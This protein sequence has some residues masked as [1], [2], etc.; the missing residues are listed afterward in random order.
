MLFRSCAGGVVF[1]Q[2]NVFLLQNEKHEWV[3]PKGVI[4]PGML[5]QEVAVMRVK[6]EAGIDARILCTAGETCYEFYSLTRK[7]PVCNE[8]AWYVMQAKHDGHHV[9]ASL[10][11][12]QGHY[13][14]VLEALATVT[15]SQDKAL[16]QLAHRKYKQY[17]G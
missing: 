17:N 8:V 9:N 10:G 6:E 3:L 2:D 14:P 12:L 13:M 5:A 1:Y 4:R 11:F 15:Y 7:M 16:I